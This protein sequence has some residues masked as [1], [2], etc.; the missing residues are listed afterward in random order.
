MFP[1]LIQGFIEENPANAMLRQSEVKVPILHYIQTVIIRM[2]LGNV[3]LDEAA[4]GDAISYLQE[5]QIETGELRCIVASAKTLCL[6]KDITTT[7][8]LYL[9]QSESL[10]YVIFVKLVI[11]IEAYYVLTIGL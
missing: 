1:V 11:R 8:T 2:I 4:C 9:Q 3:T 5:I 10:F 6:R 7:T